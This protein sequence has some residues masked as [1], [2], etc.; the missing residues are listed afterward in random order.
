MNRHGPLFDHLVGA[1]Q[2]KTA[3]P[4]DV[5]SPGPDMSKKPEPNSGWPLDIQHKQP[6]ISF[7]TPQISMRKV[8]VKKPVAELPDEEEQQDRDLW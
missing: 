5:P 8:A 4:L 1:Q 7:M 2:T 6:E 3:V